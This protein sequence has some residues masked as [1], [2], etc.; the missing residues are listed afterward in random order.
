MSQYEALSSHCLQFTGFTCILVSSSIKEN[1]VERREKLKHG[2]KSSSRSER[3]SWYQL[4]SNQSVSNSPLENNCPTY[5][6]LFSL[7]KESSC[8]PAVIADTKQGLLEP[9]ICSLAP[10]CLQSNEAILPLFS[11]DSSFES[12]LAISACEGQERL[13]CTGHSL[14]TCAFTCA[15]SE[16]LLFSPCLV[17]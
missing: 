14:V 10:C 5:P 7:I 13:P 6:N 2:C 4:W 1:K 11:A 9:N 17:K 16:R 3:C 8:D 12:V 15:C